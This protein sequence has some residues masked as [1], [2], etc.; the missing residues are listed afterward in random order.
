M[1]LSTLLN[2]ITSVTQDCDI[3]GLTQDSREVEKGFVFVVR[4]GQTTHGSEYISQAIKKGANVVLHEKQQPVE[5]NSESVIT[6]GVENLEQRLGEIAANFY[7]NPSAD[8]T[9]IGITGT[10]GKT[11][12]S[13]FI[14]QALDSL[15]KVCGVIGTLGYGL[16][17]DLTPGLHTTPEPINIQKWLA[18]LKSQGAKYVAMEASS[19]GLEQGRANG[20]EFDIAVFTNLTRDH[21]D[22]HGN[23][24]QYGRAKRRL[25][26]FPYLKKAVINLDD[27]F[28]RQ[29]AQEFKQK[30]P[31]MTFGLDKPAIEGSSHVTAKDMQLTTQ[32]IKAQITCEGEQASLTSPLLGRINMSNLL[33]ATTVLMALDIPLPQV[34]D[35]LSHATTVSGRMQPFRQITGPLVVIDYA[36]T[37]DALEKALSTLRECCDGLL[38]CVFGCGGGRDTGKRR[39]MAEAVETYADQIVVTDDNPR[40]EDPENITDEILQGIMN[41]SAVIVE[42]DRAQ[43]IKFAMDQAGESDIVLVAGKG[44]EAFQVIGEERR[45][46]SDIKVVEALLNKGTLA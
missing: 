42:H 29:L 13:H 33:T 10:N 25:F 15:G 41:V 18:K 4:S 31:I 16:F 44:H 22:Y 7:G 37:P 20:I 21:L 5:W 9:V 35:S 11:S 38:W 27:E 17:G 26:E 43:A 34:V 3:Q 46:F 30:Y 23:M 1:Q 32:G 24:Q 8:M 45:P 6:L 36:H 2:N 28:G 12:C 40:E 39:A 19:H 14:A